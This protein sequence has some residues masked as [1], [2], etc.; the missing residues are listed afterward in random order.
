MAA[1]VPILTYHAVTDVARSTPLAISPGRF[2]AQMAALAQEGYRAAPLS[3]LIG[4]LREGR[5]ER[6]PQRTVAIT[7]DDGYRSVLETAAPILRAHG[8]TATLFLVTGACGAASGR[9]PAP[10]W[11]PPWPMLNW[12]E[13][14]T[15]AAGGFELGAHT[16]TH[17]ALPHLSPAEAERE[18]VESKIEIARQTGQEV[19]AFAYPYG[20]CSVGVVALARRHF[21]LAC[22]ARLGLAGPRSDLFDLE[23]VD[24]HYLTPDRLAGRLETSPAR[25]YLAVRRVLRR[26]RRLV[27]PDWRIA[28]T[29][30]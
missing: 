6:L 28:W 20:A 21:D 4:P 18:M 12:D 3:Q 5:P 8:F 2:A 10:P 29:P 14:G 25:T 16:Q 17:P 9:R 27:R 7:F 19:R 15:L 30:A 26:A 1:R 22:G 23:R 13:I 11:Q 24:A